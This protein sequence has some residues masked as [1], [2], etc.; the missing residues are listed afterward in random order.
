LIPERGCED[1]AELR[2]VGR[3]DCGKMRGLVSK[4]RSSQM[5]GKRV[6]SQE[7]VYEAGGGAAMLEGG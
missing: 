2:S 7:A 5:R 1:L 6:G 4:R 3:I